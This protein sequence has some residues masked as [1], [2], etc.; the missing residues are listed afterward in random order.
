MSGQESFK[1]NNDM[2]FVK[3]GE[4]YAREAGLSIAPTAARPPQPDVRASPRAFPWRR[5]THRGGSPL[6]KLG[7]DSRHPVTVHLYWL[8][9]TKRFSNTC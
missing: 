6:S 2:C 3:E 8:K 1:Q 7:L 9:G 5:R 4:L